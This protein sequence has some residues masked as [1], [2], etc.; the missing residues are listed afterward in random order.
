MAN[1]K[2]PAPTS[3]NQCITPTDSATKSKRV[4]QRAEQRKNT[5]TPLA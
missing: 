3:A 4:K 2:A 5:S 1:K